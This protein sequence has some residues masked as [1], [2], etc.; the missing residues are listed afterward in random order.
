VADEAHNICPQEP[1]DALETAATRHAVKIA[2][3][4]RKFGLYLLLASQRPGKIHANILSQCDNLVLMKMIS[5]SDLAY[6][7]QGFSQAPGTFLDQSPHFAQGECLLA[8]KIVQ[9]PTFCAFE[10]RLSE[11][12]GTDVPASWTSRTS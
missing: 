8:G 7:S 10:G 3:E 4:G 5:A 11:E 12:G 9:N 2:G 1:A 6:V